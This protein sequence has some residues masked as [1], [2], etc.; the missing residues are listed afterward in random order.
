[1]KEDEVN[2]KCR[3]WLEKQGYDYKGILNARPKENCSDN[4]YG[5]VPAPD[6]SRDGLG[7]V[8][9]DHQGKKDRPADL[10][11]IEAKGSG[12]NFSTLLEG[13][14]RVVYA[15]YWGGGKG[16][17]AVPNKEYERAIE[18]K[19]FLAQVAQAAERQMGVLNAEDIEVTWF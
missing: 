11:W 10:I 14:I 1:M 4:G 5:Q 3:E 17:L 16:L 7:Q 15:C 13:Y 6:G 12:V 9:I 19:A 2:L 8:L 18:Q